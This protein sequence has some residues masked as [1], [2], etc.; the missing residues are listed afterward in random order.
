MFHIGE[1]KGFCSTF[2]SDLQITLNFTMIKLLNLLP[3]PQKKIKIIFQ[4]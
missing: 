3:P 2:D 1:R 4:R